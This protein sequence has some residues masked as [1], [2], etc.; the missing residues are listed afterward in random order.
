M[1]GAVVGVGLFL[2]VSIVIFNFLLS[3][4]L[5]VIFTVVFEFAGATG[6]TFGAET[7][8]ALTGAVVAGDG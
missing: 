5:G 7:G 1:T 6:I 4:V 8:S 2:V 3:V